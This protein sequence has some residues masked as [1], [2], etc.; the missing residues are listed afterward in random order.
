MKG[1]FPKEELYHIFLGC[2]LITINIYFFIFVHM[3]SD[4][5]PNFALA[6]FTL[7]FAYFE[8]KKAFQISKESGE[9]RRKNIEK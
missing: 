6:V 7:P 5:N 1:R 9:K 8:I 2:V 4:L 3:W